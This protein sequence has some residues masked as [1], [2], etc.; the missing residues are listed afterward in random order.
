M[1]AVS[2]PT[3][4]H[5]DNPAAR[6]RMAL[7]DTMTIAWRNTK[8]MQRVPEVVVFSTIQPVTTLI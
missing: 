7:Q 5:P 8:G 3:A 1:A 2:I 4:A 6:I